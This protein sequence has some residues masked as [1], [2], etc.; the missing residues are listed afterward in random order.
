MARF[1]GLSITEVW[2]Q[3]YYN[4]PWAQQLLDGH[5][6]YWDAFFVSAVPGY[7][8]EEGRSVEREIHV[9]IMRYGIPDDVCPFDSIWFRCR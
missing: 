4:R 6:H 2:W 9:A 3:S 8:F 1:L 5:I 7:G